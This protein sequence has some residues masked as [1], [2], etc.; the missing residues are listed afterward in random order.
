M[1][2]VWHMAKLI[3]CKFE[4]KGVK[5]KK[6][7]ILCFVLTMTMT[8]CGLIKSKL[9]IDSILDVAK[10]ITSDKKSSDDEMDPSPDQG[11]E[12]ELSEDGVYEAFEN[13]RLEEIRQSLLNT[14]NNENQEGDTR[15]EAQWNRIEDLR[16]MCKVDSFGVL[17]MLYPTI[18]HTATL[19][20]T[21]LTTVTELSKDLPEDFA[22]TVA[23]TVK[24]K[25][26]YSARTSLALLEK[27]ASGDV[28]TQ[29][30]WLKEAEIRK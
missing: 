15:C 3:R 18:A 4:S 10:E 20:F 12:G 25:S 7:F 6:A 8:S 13:E 14:F 27:I 29:E 19:A 21:G 1:G 24:G 17:T 5:M 9:P 16:I 22:I 2:K 11:F 28:S 23:L 30:E 26:V